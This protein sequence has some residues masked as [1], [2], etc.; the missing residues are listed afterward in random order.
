LFFINIFNLQ[1]L[2][3]TGYGSWTRVKPNEAFYGNAC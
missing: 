3:L 1:N 2:S